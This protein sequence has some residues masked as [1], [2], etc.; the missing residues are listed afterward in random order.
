MQDGLF[1]YSLVCYVEFACV[2]FLPSHPRGTI[3]ETRVDI[4]GGYTYN[5]CFQFTGYDQFRY[6]R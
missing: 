6:K 4:R 1:E 3:Y 2:H 5:R